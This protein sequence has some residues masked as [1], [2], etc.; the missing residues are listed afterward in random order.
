MLVGELGGEDELHLVVG[1]RD[2]ERRQQ[3]GDLPLGVEPVGEDP[4]QALR[5][6]VVEPRVALRVDV[7]IEIE[8]RPLV[9]LPVLVERGER[10]RLLLQLVDA[11]VKPLHT[12]HSPLDRDE[13]GDQRHGRQDRQPADRPEHLVAV[14]ARQVRPQDVDRCAGDERADQQADALRRR[15]E[16]GDSAAV[17]L[18]A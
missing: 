11:R 2:D 7:E 4:A 10:S 16:A 15:R 1:R 12:A 8:E 9:A 3:P 5:R 6:L 13:P 17:L 14:R 18:A